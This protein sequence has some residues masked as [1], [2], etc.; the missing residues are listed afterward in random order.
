MNRY[1]SVA[2]MLHWTIAVLIITNLVLGFGRGMLPKGMMAMPI[3]KSI[4]ITVLVL[5]VLRILWRLTHRPPPL[6]GAM[7]VWERASATLVHWAFYAL[8]IV[9]PL[10]GW[11]ISSAGDR[12]LNW[13]FLF[14]I[15]KLAV[16]K[17]DGLYGLSHEAHE[18]LPWLWIALIA[19]HVGAALRHHFVLKDDVLR[20]MVRGEPLADTDSG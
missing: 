14:D 16:S 6:P 7:P 20:R 17:T 8:M 19:L 4:G 5:T 9:L 10:S 18:L 15:P 2:R 12:P 3:H 11:I 13:F 1:T